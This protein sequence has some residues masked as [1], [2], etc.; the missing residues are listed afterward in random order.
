MNQPSQSI[1]MSNPSRWLACLRIVVG[2]YFAKALW[3][4]MSIVLAGGFFPLPAAS[5]RWIETMPQ[6]VAKQASENPILWYKGFLEGTVLPN[7]PLFAQMIAWAECIVGIGLTLGLFNGVAS[8]LGF[9]L[10]VN[11]G[12][13]TQ[14]MSAGQRGFH[15]VLVSCML[16]FFLARSGRAWGLDGWLAWRFGDRWFTGRPF[17]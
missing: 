13:A 11:Y 12:L 4:K 16:V 9:F 5:A 3:T 8:V 6:I 14:W 10:S 7:G 15:I 1:D 17:A 2:L